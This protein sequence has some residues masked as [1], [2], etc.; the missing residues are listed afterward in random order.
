VN[1]RWLAPVVVLL[2]TACASA[3]ANQLPYQ[4]AGEARA[5][6]AKVR[7]EWEAEL[8]R[9]VRTNPSRYFQ[10]LS[11]GEFLRRLRPAAARH[12]FEIVR[13]EFRKPR[14]LAPLVVVRANDVERLADA[15]PRF[16]RSIDPKARTTD[17]R[18]GWSWEGFLFEARDADGVPGFVVFHWWRARQ[19]VGGGQW[20]RRE[21]PYPFAHG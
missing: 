17:D 21:S 18:I 3:S 15:Y 4:D 13:V 2:L 20:A 19:S 6:V 5:A 10:N 14:Q 11:R 1:A 9:G 7:R 12:A 8:A 16:W